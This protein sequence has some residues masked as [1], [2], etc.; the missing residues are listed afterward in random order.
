MFRP[1]FAWSLLVDP[2]FCRCSR[3]PLAMP[4]QMCANRTTSVLHKSCTQQIW[5]SYWYQK[6]LFDTSMIR[7]PSFM[8]WFG[9]IPTWSTSDTKKSAASSMAANPNLASAIFALGWNWPNNFQFECKQKTPEKSTE[10]SKSIQKLNSNKFDINSNPQILVLR[11]SSLLYFDKT[12]NG[13]PV[14]SPQA[15]LLVVHNLW[16]Q[17]ELVGSRWETKSSVI[18]SQQ[19][20]QDCTIYTTVCR[21]I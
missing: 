11:L 18:G 19:K 15:S 3:L 7:K 20:C 16:S 9:N 6:I 1:L 13:K 5:T 4:L 2:A 17:G 8:Y 14:T 12:Q 10:H 21:Y